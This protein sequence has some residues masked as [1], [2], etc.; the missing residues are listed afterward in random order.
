MYLTYIRIKKHLI[1]YTTKPKQILADVGLWLQEKKF[2]GTFGS[3]MYTVQHEVTRGL[4][5]TVSL[6]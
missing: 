2:S 3:E 5:Q 1:S 6:L 4:Q